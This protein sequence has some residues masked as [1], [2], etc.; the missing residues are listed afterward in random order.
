MFVSVKLH[1]DAR[2]TSVE[3]TKFTEE[4]KIS[5]FQFNPYYGTLERQFIW[6]FCVSKNKSEGEKKPEDFRK[7]CIRRMGLKRKYRDCVCRISFPS[8]NP[9]DP[10]SLVTL[11]F[12]FP[13]LLKPTN[14]ESMHQISAR[15]RK[16]FLFYYQHRNHPEA[17]P[18]PRTKFLL[19]LKQ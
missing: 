13:Y 6:A 18:F 17:C 1:L 12:S 4:S 5:N 7:R 10:S 11:K 15:H 14:H 2:S 8:E 16:L 3:V 19:M 9:K